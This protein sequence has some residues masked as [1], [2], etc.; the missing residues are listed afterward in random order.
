[1]VLLGD[2]GGYTISSKA[3]TDEK[4]DWPAS[5]DEDTDLLLLLGN[6]HAG[7]RRA[8]YEDRYRCC[9]KLV[10]RMP[11]PDLFNV[12]GS[13]LMQPSVV[14]K[15]KPPEMQAFMQVDMH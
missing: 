14:Q 2:V 4:T 9:I 11:P 13:V 5:A 6:R 1:M 10:G 7:W 8:G 12:P 15:I 3:V